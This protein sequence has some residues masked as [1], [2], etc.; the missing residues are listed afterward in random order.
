MLEDLS[1]KAK[2]LIKLNEDETEKVQI[3]LDKKLN[4]I[5]ELAE[6]LL[7]KVD[8]DG[9][10]DGIDVGVLQDLKKRGYSKSMAEL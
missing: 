5:R 2:I 3:T 7:K 10:I 4:E 9:G 1:T 8:L 6:Q